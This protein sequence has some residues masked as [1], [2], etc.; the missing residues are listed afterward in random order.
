MDSNTCR[1]TESAH[2]EPELVGIRKFVLVTDFHSVSFSRLFEDM[3]IR[4]QRR[5][6]L[7]GFRC[8]SHSNQAVTRQAVLYTSTQSHITGTKRLNENKISI[9]LVSF[10]ERKHQPLLALSLVRITGLLLF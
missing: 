8:V 10:T 7:M 9:L 2:P 6:T 4:F 3:G 1:V 5:T